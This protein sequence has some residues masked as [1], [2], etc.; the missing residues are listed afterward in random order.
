MFPHPPRDMAITLQRGATHERLGDLGV[1]GEGMAGPEGFISGPRLEIVDL[2]LLITFPVNLKSS[3]SMGFD[4][5]DATE[6][7]NLLS[8]KVST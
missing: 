2:F 5:E 7:A 3:N 4:I 6:N 1:G 8:G